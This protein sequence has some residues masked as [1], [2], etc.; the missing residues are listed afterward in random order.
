[1][2][3][4]SNLV[5]LWSYSVEGT[6][7]F[8]TTYLSWVRESVSS[9]GLTIAPMSLLPMF[10]SII[11]LA[12]FTYI[13]FDLVKNRWSERHYVSSYFVQS[14]DCS[15]YI[16]SMII[17]FVLLVIHPSIKFSSVSEYFRFFLVREH[18]AWYQHL[19]MGPPP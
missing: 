19:A 13:F 2:S 15:V 12:V 16:F 3:R 10:L 7:L 18:D 17:V 5:V 14:T 11:I 6:E 4:S 1:M 9:W 8:R